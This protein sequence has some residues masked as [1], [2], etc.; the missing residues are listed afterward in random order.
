VQPQYS[1]ATCDRHQYPWP[2]TWRRNRS[3]LLTSAAWPFRLGVLQHDRFGLASY[4]T[5]SVQNDIIKVVHLAVQQHIFGG[6]G[7]EMCSSYSFTT[8][9]LDGVSGHRHA[10]SALYPR[11]RTPGT[12]CTGGWV[13]PRAGLYTEVRGR[14]LFPLPGIEPQS[15]ARPVH[16]QTLYWLSYS[17]WC[18]LTF[19]DILFLLYFF[20]KSSL[21]LLSSQLI[22]KTFTVF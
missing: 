4:N 20:R 15:R 1:P 8:S 2:N 17:A 7:G 11:E 13:G 21:S 10:P 18:I 6:A 19:S 14:I 3:I 22:H 12:H 9:S 5:I 16:S